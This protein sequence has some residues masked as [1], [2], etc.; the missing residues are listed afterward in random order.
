MG[1]ASNSRVAA[2]PPSGR[3]RRVQDSGLRLRNRWRVGRRFRVERPRWLAVERPP[4]TRWL[5]QSRRAWARPMLEGRAGRQ[6]ASTM[7]ARR[8]ERNA[9][10]GPFHPPGPIPTMMLGICCWGYLTW[11]GRRSQSPAAR[12]RDE[13]FRC[14]RRGHR[15][16]QLRC[17][18]RR[19]GKSLWI[20]S[21]FHDSTVDRHRGAGW[22]CLPQF[23][24]EYDAYGYHSDGL[25]SATSG[26]DVEWRSSTGVYTDGPSETVSG[27]RVARVGEV[28]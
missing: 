16:A 9:V 24:P 23:C 26:V 19:K 4:M 25:P 21:G 6:P 27:G 10:L 15:S 17:R 14:A 7:P 12:G 11:S 28:I 3:L 5:E 13:G 8:R 2:T 22:R 18:V 20:C 1:P